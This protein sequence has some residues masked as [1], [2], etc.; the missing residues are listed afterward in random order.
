MNRKQGWTVEFKVVPPSKQP[1]C[2][3]AKY[4][5]QDGSLNFFGEQFK[6]PEQAAR[7]AAANMIKSGYVE[8]VK[9]RMI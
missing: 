6:N 5:M 2:V 8:S 3:G 7:F 4:P 1:Y 9:V